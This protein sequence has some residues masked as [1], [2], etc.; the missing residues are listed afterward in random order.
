MVILVESYSVFSV[1]LT[2]E[3][4][5]PVPGEISAAILPG[6]ALP[7][8]GT[9][10]LQSPVRLRCYLACSR[11]DTHSP[12]APPRQLLSPRSPTLGRRRRP[13]CV[14]SLPRGSSCFPRS[15]RNLVQPVWNSLSASVLPRYI[16]VAGE[17]V[18]TTTGVGISCKGRVSRGFVPADSL[19]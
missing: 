12:L 15:P 4:V 8:K 17:H 18:W 9:L 19:D 1:A 3:E 16:A 10:S 11:L 14:V 5:R 2:R 13:A 6:E 7:A